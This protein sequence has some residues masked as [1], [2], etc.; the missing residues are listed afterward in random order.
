[1]RLGGTIP[2]MRRRW[3]PIAAGARARQ[4][5]PDIDRGARTRLRRPRSPCGGYI[6]DH[7]DD[8]GGGTAPRTTVTDGYG[9]RA[10]RAAAGAGGGSPPSPREPA[11]GGPPT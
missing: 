6:V 9:R 5:T 10:A 8:G 1:M 7:I 4:M 11:A 3:R 2:D